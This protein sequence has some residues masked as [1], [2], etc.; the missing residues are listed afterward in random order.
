MTIDL[1][2]KHLSQIQL[3]TLE[4]Q[5]SLFGI[6]APSKIALLL[7][8]LLLL[9]VLG[10]VA[11]FSGGKIFT[12]IS[13]DHQGWRYLSVGF[14][15]IILIS[16]IDLKCRGVL[17]MLVQSIGV[18]FVWVPLLCL[19]LLGMGWLQNPG[20]KML[21][22]IVFNA[23][24]SGFAILSTVAFAVIAQLLNQALPTQYP[25]L[26]GVLIILLGVIAAGTAT[27][28]SQ[29]GA[30]DS[31]T[32]ELLRQTLNPPPGSIESAVVGG[33]AWTGVVVLGG[34]RLSEAMTRS[35]PR[36][37]WLRQACT[38]IAAWGG[39]SFYDLD[40]SGINFSDANVANSD[41]RGKVL[42]RTCL[43][44]LNGLDR[45]RVDRRYLD[46]DQ[47]KVQKLLTTG[48]AVE[49]D[50]Q[51]MNLQGAFLQKTDLQGMNFAEATLHGADL[52]GDILRGASFLRT[53]VT[54]VDFSGADLTGCCIKDWSTNRQT[55]FT[56]AICNYVYREFEQEQPSDRYPRDR[57]FEPE[58]FADLHRQ[59]DNST[60][61]VFQGV[62]DMRALSFAFEKFKLEDDG[63]G[64]ELQ[65]IE[66]RGDLWIV[67]VAHHEGVTPQQVKQQVNSTYDDLK[68]LFEARYQLAL[69]AKEGEIAR[70]ATHNESQQRFIQ[71]LVTGVIETH[72]K[73]LIQGEGN[74]VY[75]VQQSGDIMES[76]DI[77][78][79]GNVDTS[80]GAKVSIDGDVT[81]ST[82]NLGTISGN[83]TSLI[84]QLRESPMQGSQDLAQ[85][86]GELQ[87]GIQ[88]E[89]QLAEPH[90]QEAL[91]AVATLAQEAK[92]PPENRT[93]KL[94]TM[95]MNALK[96]AT[97]TLSDA[98]KL[99]EIIKNALPLL[100]GFL[101]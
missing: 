82:L 54:G 66:Q 47:P 75:M 23:L 64:L 77:R 95:A 84:Q 85:I 14:F 80:S 97:A 7:L 21:G 25:V 94:C 93:A 87:S 3:A 40:L 58:E 92:K 53:R 39:T 57:D 100:K 78:A 30:L 6:K 90:K 17:A 49:K 12:D 98:S 74:R 55:N 42:H 13:F 73:V 11:G 60:E 48:I 2:S 38:A 5:T 26:Q 34:L 68:A 18:S 1:R 10:M 44:G 86:L 35:H 61:L 81:G 96:G 76:Q 37:L 65:G 99:A 8:S 20:E 56:G 29:A 72:G 32:L 46:L 28:L 91:E 22:G 79:G 59:I 50:F 70:L 101:V 83:V 52:Q 19:L 62:T 4:P 16:T 89:A 67:K 69:E 31:T 63:L 15:T 51:R 71:G 88:S 9:G 43:I 41:F 33:L 27:Q 36:F 45:A 24:F